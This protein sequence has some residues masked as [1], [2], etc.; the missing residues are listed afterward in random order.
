MPYQRF[1]A[2]TPRG[3]TV[4]YLLHQSIQVLDEYEALGYSITLRQLYYQLVSRDVMPNAQSY[5]KRLGDVITKAREAG[6]I[7]WNAIVDRGRTPIM[8]PHWSSAASLMQAA[9]S[10]FRLDRWAD[11]PR[12][13]EL[14]CEKD[15]LSSILEPIARQYHVHMLANRGYSSA[16]AMWQAAQ[17]I[18]DAYDHGQEPVIL[19]LGDHDP[20]GIDMTRDVVERLDLLSFQTPVDII[21][22]ALNFD[23]V[24]THNPPPNPTKQTDSRAAGYLANYG[25]DS[26]ELDALNPQTLN[27]LVTDQIENLLDHDLYDQQLA[28]EEDIKAQLLNLAHQADDNTATNPP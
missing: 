18:Q 27:Q 14:W 8:P 4:K 22:I 15:A 19:Y 7:D 6:L 24:L 20:S 23:Q 3:D 12:Y 16:T 25:P 13:V 1:T 21:R 26:W 28:R 17:R 2:W 5:Y 10:Q 9:A 11:Q